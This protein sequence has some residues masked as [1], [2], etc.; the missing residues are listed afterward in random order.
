M[1]TASGLTPAGFTFGELN[2][3]K[4]KRLILCVFSFFFFVWISVSHYFHLGNPSLSS[5][6]LNTNMQG[7]RNQPGITVSFHPNLR[8]LISATNK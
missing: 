8:K 3:F 2:L 6:R 5:A 1:L 7:G 4:L